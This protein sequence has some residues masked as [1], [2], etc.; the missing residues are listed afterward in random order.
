MP[1]TWLECEESGQMEIAVSREYLLGKAFLWDTRETFCS[2]SLSS[3]IHT[4]FANTIYT[5]IIH[6]CWGELLRENPSETTWKFEI[7]IPTI[8]YTLF[9]EFPHLLPF[10]FHTIERLIAQTLTTPFENV[11]WSFGTAGKYWKKPRMTDT[12]W[13]LLRDPES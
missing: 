3:L 10:H 9:W 7:I 4:F 11:K 13:S 1:C 6:K 12:T 5:H 2:A 8:L